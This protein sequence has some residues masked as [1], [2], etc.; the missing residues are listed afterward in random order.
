M[1]VETGDYRTDSIWT[2]QPLLLII[3][4]VWLQIFCNRLARKH[5]THARQQTLVISPAWPVLQASAVLAS[6][7]GSLPKVYWRTWKHMII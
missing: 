2:T 7:S 6:F 3:F 5:T 4:N 1:S